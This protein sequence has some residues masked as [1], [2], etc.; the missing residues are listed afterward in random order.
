MLSDIDSREL[1]QN[2]WVILKTLLFST[3]VLHQSILD[4]IMFLP[5]MVSFE[6][7]SLSL[8]KS[9]LRTLSALSFIIATFGGVTAVQEMKDLEEGRGFPELKRVFYMAMDILS[10]NAKDSE[11]FVKELT[12]STNPNQC[13]SA[14]L[15]FGG[16]M[17]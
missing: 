17:Y 9:I 6:I 11:E 8:S 14:L 12:A 5:S 3:I 1:T 2:L 10:T 15:H 13:K 16:Y 7:T 4:T